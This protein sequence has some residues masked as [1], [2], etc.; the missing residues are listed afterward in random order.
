MDKSLNIISNIT[1]FLPVALIAG[2]FFSD[3]IVSV[4][5]IFFLYFCI[6]TKNFNLFNNNLSKLFLLFWLYIVFTSFFSEKILVS[7]KVSIPYIRFGL[8]VLLIGYLIN[9]KKGYLEKFSILTIIVYCGV[10]FDSYFQFIFGFNIFGF[11]SPRNDR[12]SSFFGDEMI[13]G[14]FLSRLFPFV[15]F[16]ILIASNKFNNKIKFLSPFLLIFTDVII[17]LSGERTSFGI[18]MIINIGYLLLISQMRIIRLITFVISLGIIVVITNLSSIT[19]ERMINQTIKD[20]GIKGNKIN[21]FSEIHQDHYET[22]SKMFID[23]PLKGVGVKMFRYECSKEKFESG[24]FSCT[25]HPH[26]LHLQLLAET[27]VIG[28]FFIF[29]LFFFITGKFLITIKLIYIDKKNDKSNDLKNCILLGIF[30]NLF[31]LMPSGNFFNNWLSILYFLP[32]GFYFLKNNNYA[33]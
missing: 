21:L 27:G 1:L 12:L 33:K 24:K 26:H 32:I 5:A 13:V 28:Y 15:L 30:V 23:N 10:L 6:K 11:V 25:T 22:A 8:F 31:P 16:C 9:N 19:K 17:F 14:S 2:P 18:L 7:L 4:S 29:Y 3:L 20:F